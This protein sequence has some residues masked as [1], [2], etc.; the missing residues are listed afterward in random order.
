MHFKKQRRNLILKVTFLISLTLPFLL[1]YE[2]NIEQNG[3]CSIKNFIKFFSCWDLLFLF[4]LFILE[5]EW[6]GHVMTQHGG[7]FPPIQVGWDLQRIGQ[8]HYLYKLFYKHVDTHSQS[9]KKRG[10]KACD[11]IDKV[12]T[13]I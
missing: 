9:R 1:K 2:I 11:K 4:W 13:A 10:I 5:S 7:H 8:I 12:T 3:N 6:Y